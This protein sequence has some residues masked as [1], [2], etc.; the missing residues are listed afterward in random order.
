MRYYSILFGGGTMSKSML[1]IVNGSAGTKQARKGLSDI[2]EIFSKAGYAPITKITAKR[3]DAFDLIEQYGKKVEKIVCIGGDGTLNEVTSSMI[4][5]DCHTPLGYIPAG[6]TNDFATTVGI[7]KDIFKAAK[8]II[9]GTPVA[10]D[11][12]CF[13][14]RFFTYVASFGAFTRASYSTPQS[15][16]N[17]LGH[18]AYIL[19][20]IKEI[21]DIHPEHLKIVTES[22][23]Y[24]GDFLIGFISNST[25]LGG[26]ITLDSDLV[27]LKDG[28]FELVLVKH[29]KTLIELNET[30]LAIRMQNYHS[31][32]LIFTTASEAVIYADSEMNWTLD[33]EFAPGK[34]VIK[35]KN[36]K[37]AINYILKK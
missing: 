2:L 8:E 30:M 12:G 9:E 24:Q 25:S 37:E 31:P 5:T 23:V 1:L 27:D 35:I 11:I 10:L 3:E 29:P 33:G 22:D 13:N 7:S 28:K 18:A 20:G 15:S 21:P 32:R 16:K 6:T 19:E 34:K 4:R 14:D 26:I 17:M 36:K